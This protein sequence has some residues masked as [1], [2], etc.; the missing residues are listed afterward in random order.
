MQITVTKEA[1]NWF[2]D[3]MGVKSGEGVR[4]FGKVYGKTPVHDG[5]SLGMVRDDR[6]LHP[7]SKTEFDGVH[8]FVDRLDEW[9]FKGYDLT[10][11]YDD[12]TDGPKYDYKENGELK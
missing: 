6:P 9:F 10:V 8:Y 7:S 11:D 3:E 1:S 4:F 2:H 12:K 5:F